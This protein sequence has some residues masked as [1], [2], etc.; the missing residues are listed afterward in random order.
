MEENRLKALEKKRKRELDDLN[1]QPSAI[2]AEKQVEFQ[3]EPVM[4]SLT[5]EQKL[6]EYCKEMGFQIKEKKPVKSSTFAIVHDDV[7]NQDDMAEE[8]YDEEEDIND[9][10]KEML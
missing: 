7:H 10:I 9:D 5:S 4:N 1:M 3:Q 6:D 2:P 8:E